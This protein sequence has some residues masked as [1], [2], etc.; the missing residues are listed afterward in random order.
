MF[1]MDLMRMIRSARNLM[2]TRF[3]LVVFGQELRL[4]R[5]AAEE[6]FDEIERLDAQLNAHHPGSEISQINAHAFRRTVRV[7]TG[8]FKLLLSAKQLSDETQRAFDISIAPLMQF[9]GFYENNWGIPNQPELE[10]VLKRVGMDG[11]ELNEKEATIQFTR[12]GM[13][14]DLGAIGKGYAID[15]AAKILR[16]SGIQS[17]II[18]GGCSS[19]LTIGHPPGAPYWRLAIVN[20]TAGHKMIHEPKPVCSQPSI[21]SLQLEIQLC[22]ESLSVSSIWGKY[23]RRNGQWITHLINPQDGMPIVDNQLAAVIL[24]NTMETDALSTAL[25]VTGQSGWRRMTK[26]RK[27]IRCLLITTKGVKRH[28]IDPNGYPES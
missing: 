24:P 26:I 10:S 28:H 22:N 8:L 20:D 23:Y 17:A 16:D 2:A 18:Q 9:W 5:E 6:A 11:I 12:P 4:L 1:L 25:L 27:N 13:Q 7:E 15:Q 3:E 21:K 14:L 19:I